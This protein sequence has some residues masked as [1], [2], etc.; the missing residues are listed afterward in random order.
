MVGEVGSR[1]WSLK[2]TDVFPPSA[3]LSWPVALHIGMGLSEISPIYAG[4]ELVWLL[5]LSFW[6]TSCW[7]FM[8]ATSLAYKRHYFIAKSPCSGLFSLPSLSC[9]LSLGYKLY[10]RC[11]NR[12]WAFHGQLFFAFW[13][14]VA[15]DKGPCL[16]KKKLFWWTVREMLIF[17]CKDKPNKVHWN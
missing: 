7:D 10:C 6:Q 9:P 2:N 12:F 8:G 11:I 16:H 1:V 4:C 13:L 17:V 15:F 3:A 5:C 14:A